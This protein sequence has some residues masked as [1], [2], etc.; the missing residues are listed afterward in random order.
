MENNEQKC[1]LE[2]A[3]ITS[4]QAFD[5]IKTIKVTPSLI[6]GSQIR[7]MSASCYD[8][9]TNC[10]Y[11]DLKNYRGLL[12]FEEKEYNHYSYD[13]GEDDEMRYYPYNRIWEINTT[14]DHIQIKYCPFCGRYLGGED[15]D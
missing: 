9:P 14:L 7:I 12:Q 6:E 2:V 4:R 8:K 10:E 15:A 3:D 11:C 5:I 1:V 13:I